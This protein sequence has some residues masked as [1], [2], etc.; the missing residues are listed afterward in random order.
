MD[1]RSLD[2]RDAV[3]S[4]MVPSYNSL[5]HNLCPATLDL[6]S[7]NYVLYLKYWVRRWPLRRHSQL[8]AML[9]IPLCHKPA[10]ADR[11]LRERRRNAVRFLRR[12]HVSRCHEHTCMS[13]NSV[14]DSDA[15]YRQLF[16]AETGIYA[17]IEEGENERYK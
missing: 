11:E 16:G 15:R 5:E 13:C 3:V 10:A 17:Q 1:K 12:I 6:R 4:C 9:P 7:L 2:D 8:T 14:N